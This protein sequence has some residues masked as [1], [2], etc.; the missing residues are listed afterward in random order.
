MSAGRRRRVR[1]GAD[2]SSHRQHGAVMCLIRRA[3]RQSAAGRAVRIGVRAYGVPEAAGFDGR[4]G[5]WPD[6]FSGQ[7]GRARDVPDESCP[8][9]GERRSRSSSG[10]RTSRSRC[11]AWIE[12]GETS[13]I[14]LF[15]IDGCARRW[16]SQARVTR[17]GT[18]A[19]GALR[20]RGRGASGGRELRAFLS[21]K[22]WPRRGHG[23]VCVGGALCAGPPTPNGKV[24]QEGAA[25][26]GDAGK[27]RAS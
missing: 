27:A 12:L 3:S 17:L 20:R 24:G 11:V 23:A 1:R 14:L 13:T 5:L 15:A 22:E 18:A 7:R 6:P 2:R 26:A 16:R 8:L 10:A 4:A 19:G 25:R 9:A 21:G